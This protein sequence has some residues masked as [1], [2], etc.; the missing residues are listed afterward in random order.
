MR[1]VRNE[2]GRYR[3]VSA[4]ETVAGYVRRLDLAADPFA[5]DFESDYFYRGAQR[6]A[7]LEQ[8]VHFSRFSDHI[9]MLLGATGSGSS[10]LL[11]EM[12]AQ[13][14]QI[15]D[16]CDIDGEGE[17]S[18]SSLLRSLAEQLQLLGDVD[19][20]DTFIATLDEYAYIGA[21]SE[22]LLLAVDQA[23]FL[24]VESFE[25]L[26]ALVQRARG[27]IRLLFVG[28]YQSEQLAELAHYD[29]QQLKIFELP[30]LTQEQTGDYILGL[31]AAAGYAGEQPLSADQLLVLQERSGGNIAEINTLAAALLSFDPVNEKRGFAIKIPIAHLAAIVILSATLGYVYWY[32][33][34]G[35]D[36]EPQSVAAALPVAKVQR[37]SDKGVELAPTPEVANPEP[38]PAASL[39]VEKEVPAAVAEEPE[40]GAAVAGVS[41]GEPR[42]PESIPAASDKLAQG[43]QGSIELTDAIAASALP[44][45]A[46]IAAPLD[47]AHSKRIVAVSAPSAA[48]TT[49]RTTAEQALLALPA[50]SY[51]LQLTG[52]VSERRIQEFVEKYS[53]RLSLSY[54]ELRRNGAP[55]YIALS[56]AEPSRQA[57]QAAVKALPEALRRQQPWVRSVASLQQALAGLH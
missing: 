7:T 43:S 32:L 36:R 44:V 40:P 16:C 50:A 45:Q 28:E 6:Q 8:V 56:A 10:R 1:R 25:L 53:H 18:P 48:A 29:R 12:L 9:V 39:V 33:G 23:H 20:L 57:A 2:L 5:D 14:H 35:E 11:D 49:H 54:I 31:L 13:L 55:W 15:M 19:S 51:M 24:P 17:S 34:L 52:S 41:T 46:I 21:E 26:L 3:P 22:P 30:A 27:S 47:G 38:D 37:H 42:A 4:D